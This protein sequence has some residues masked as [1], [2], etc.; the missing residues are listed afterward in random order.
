MNLSFS[1]IGIYLLIVGLAAVIFLNP[2][3][4]AKKMQ[5]MFKDDEEKV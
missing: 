4:T 3:R 1:Y 5:K 2:D